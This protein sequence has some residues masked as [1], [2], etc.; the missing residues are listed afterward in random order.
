M[1]YAWTEFK[2]GAAGSGASGPAG[3]RAEE[4]VFLTR[5]QTAF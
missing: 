1:D 2:G 3:N 4:K 5:F